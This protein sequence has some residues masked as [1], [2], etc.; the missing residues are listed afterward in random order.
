MKE[1]DPRIAK[2]IQKKNKIKEIKLPDRKIV[3]A[4]KTM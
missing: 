1:Q 3:T 2:T 4:M